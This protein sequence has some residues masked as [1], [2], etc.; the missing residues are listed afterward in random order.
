MVQKGFIFQWKEALLFYLP[1]KTE[2][3]LRLFLRI[4]CT[5]QKVVKLYGQVSSFHLFKRTL[6][7]FAHD[8]TRKHA[9][10]TASL[11]FPERCRFH[12]RTFLR[13]DTYHR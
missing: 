2:E 6:H 13:R 7:T 3:I 11:L 1:G 10:R 9:L 4:S 5:G 12:F 8:R